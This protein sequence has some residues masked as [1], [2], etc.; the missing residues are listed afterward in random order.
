MTIDPNHPLTLIGFTFL[1]FGVPLVIVL[2]IADRY[3][4]DP[5]LPGRILNLVQL[6]CFGVVAVL[7]LIQILGK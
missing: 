7:S 1:F 4:S 6:I 2:Y 3:S 5:D